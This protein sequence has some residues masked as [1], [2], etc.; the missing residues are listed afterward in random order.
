MCKHRERGD[1]SQSVRPCEALSTHTH[2]HTHTHRATETDETSQP[3][4]S[5][6]LLTSV[7]SATS[8]LSYA[9]YIKHA[10][11]LH[12]PNEPGWPS[13]QGGPERGSS[14]LKRRP[15]LQL[16]RRLSSS[17]P[18][19]TEL[20]QLGLW[21]IEC[22][23]LFCAQPRRKPFVFQ[24]SFTLLVPIVIVAPGLPLAFCLGHLLLRPFFSFLSLA[25]TPF[26]LVL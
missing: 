2:T 20:Q 17:L 6:I 3:L 1:L 12:W 23:S 24:V 5:V 25:H 26:V 13:P 9:A 14:R 11:Y 22:L 4:Q 7:Y 18:P 19:I 15:D 16:H 10:G 21:P 8:M